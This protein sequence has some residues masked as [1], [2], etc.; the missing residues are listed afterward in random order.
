MKSFYLIILLFLSLFSFS[1]KNKTLKAHQD[2]LISLLN[3]TRNEQDLKKSFALNVD[4]ENHLRKVL[5]YD[6]AF[7]FSFDSLSKMMS[8]ITSPDKTFRIFNWNIEMPKQEHMYFCLIMKYDQKSEEYK[9]IKLYDKSASAFDP[10]YL[11]YNNK[12]WYGALYYTIIPIKKQNSTIYIFKTV[13][14]LNSISFIF[15]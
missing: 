2:T 15:T 5:R 7:S 13:Y 9:T 14:N 11:P 10:E 12:T 8:T 4:F 6:E 3:K 1:Q